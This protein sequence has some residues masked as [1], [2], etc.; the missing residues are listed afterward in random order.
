MA[1][2]WDYVSYRIEA[3]SYLTISETAILLAS[4][5]SRL[6]P[7]AFDCGTCIM[8]Y[9]KSAKMQGKSYRKR[10]SKGCFDLKT[11][12]Y[13]LENIRY[14]NC[15]GNHVVPIDFIVDAFLHYEKGGLPF[16]GTLGDQPNKMIEIFDMFHRR[17]NEFVKNNAK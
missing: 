6:D 16:E 13:R 5:E 3:E 1:N 15:I 8:Q 9:G 10:Q 11:K 4:I 14:N 7:K 17:R 2:I 12:S